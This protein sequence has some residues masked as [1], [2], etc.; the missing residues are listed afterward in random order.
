MKLTKHYMADLSG[1]ELIRHLYQ[2]SKRGRD[3]DGFYKEQ[4]Y[5]PWVSFRCII[6]WHSETAV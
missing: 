2:N 3:T 5:F 4:P 6:A 1:W